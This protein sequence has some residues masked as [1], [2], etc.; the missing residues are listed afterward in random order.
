MRHDA[1]SCAASDG[2]AMTNNYC[3]NRVAAALLLL[4]L[5]AAATATAADAVR[6]GTVGQVR[7]YIVLCLIA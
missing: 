4:A 1:P 3:M 5:A 2:V 6:F 7:H